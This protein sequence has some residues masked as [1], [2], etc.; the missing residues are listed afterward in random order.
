MS[1]NSAAEVVGSPVPGVIPEPTHFHDRATDPSWP[2]AP[3]PR[4]P[5]QTDGGRESDWLVLPRDPWMVAGDPRRDSL[6]AVHAR[7]ASVM[8]AFEHHLGRIF[9][10]QEEHLEPLADAL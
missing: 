1:R 6:P 7:A 8:N 4:A 3:Q 9:L 2:D 5:V 10:A